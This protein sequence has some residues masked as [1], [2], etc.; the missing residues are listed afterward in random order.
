MKQVVPVLWHCV[1]VSI[2]FSLKSLR[3]RTRVLLVQGTSS[4]VP[5]TTKTRPYSIEGMSVQ[6]YANSSTASN[7]LLNV[8][9]SRIESTSS[10]PLLRPSKNSNRLSL[11]LSNPFLHAVLKARFTSEL[12]P[13]LDVCSLRSEPA[14]SNNYRE[15]PC[16]RQPLTWLIRRLSHSE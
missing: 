5:I 13:I 6:L 15:N 10:C 16:S 4:L 8:D 2:L 9:A 3:E 7:I 12:R 14:T 1:A 11:R